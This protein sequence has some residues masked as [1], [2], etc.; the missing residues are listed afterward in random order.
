MSGLSLKKQYERFL[1]EQFLEA[2][3]L[4]GEIVDD[5][6]EA[7][8]FIVKFKHELVGIEVSELFI[9][10]GEHVG[11]L[12]AQESLAQRI[13]F[14]AQR[15]YASAGA[16]HAYVSV[17]FS[18]GFDVRRLNRDEAAAALST[19][20][21]SQALSVGQRVQWR[22]DYISR[23][24]PEAITY[25]Q[26]LGVPEAKMAHWT[27]PRA[28]WMAPITETLLQAR[29][30]EKATLLP[31]YALRV[32]TNW[33]LLVGDGTRP[34]QFFEA[35]TPAIASAITSP[36]ARTFYFGRMGRVVVELGTGPG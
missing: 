9:T 4:A 31:R 36:F 28:G 20:V 34:S 35:P 23:D 5:R 30:D 29:I 25:V 32:V 22:Q 12:Q 33:L 7:P 14:N 1:L 26:M 13:V 24:L 8:D 10:E 19:F 21:I 18:P 15:L 16:Q 6:S 2:A 3:N 11:N 17:H 27:V